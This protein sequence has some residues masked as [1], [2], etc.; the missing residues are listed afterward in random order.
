MKA[1]A[2]LHWL[3]YFQEMKEEEKDAANS[4]L[5]YSGMGFQLAGTIAVGFFI[6]YGIDKWLGTKQPFFTLG[7]SVL[8]LVLAFYI[9]FR[10][11][12]KK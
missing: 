10:N 11:L 6:G 8:F 12:M 7:F 2:T 4:Y 3:F 1:D 9:V 5:K